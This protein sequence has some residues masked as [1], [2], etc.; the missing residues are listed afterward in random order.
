MTVLSDTQQQESRNLQ[1][2]EEAEELGLTATAQALSEDIAARLDKST[3]VTDDAVSQYATLYTDSMLLAW[4]LG[5]YHVM[6]MV[7]QPVTLAD[8]TTEAADLTFNEAIEFLR[9]QVPVDSDTYRNMEANLKL[10]GFTVAAVSSEQAVNDV[11]RLYEVALSTGQTS[12]EA[13]QNINAYLTQAGVSPT[14]P[15][16]L[17]LHYRNNMMTSYN[18][19][20][21]TQVIDNDMVQYLVY[22]S[23]LDDGTTELCRHLDNTV[24]AKGDTFWQKYWPPNHHKCR[25]TVTP[26]TEYQYEQLPNSVKETSSAISEQSLKQN[27]TMAAEHQF[28]GSPVNSMSTL[29]ASL[30]AQAEKFDMVPDILRYTQSVSGDVLTARN[31]VLSTSVVSA[32]VVKQAV[33]GNA[34]LDAFAEL[35]ATVPQNADEVWL[36]FT[37]LYGS[38]PTLAIQYL[39]QADDNT[40]L[41][42][43]A[44]AYSDEGVMQ[45]LSM[46]QTEYDALRAAP[47]PLS[48]SK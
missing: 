48:E 26:F 47:L 37:E 17:E 22:A 13:R 10:R 8:D 19:G 25:A 30:M 36:G 40:W 33:A 15:Y 29:P 23:V 6:Q 44:P 43:Y 9:S 12:A 27:S 24:K 41:A 7:A 5:Q 28:K 4:L 45:L 38:D 32:E 11:K 35:A 1:Q 39:L 18:A 21:W 20:R 14:N 42:A 34:E 2:L 46:T 16:Y 3:V 31:A